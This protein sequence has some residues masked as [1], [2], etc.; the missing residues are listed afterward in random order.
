MNL[1]I[2]DRLI[3]NLTETDLLQKFRILVAFAESLTANSAKLPK[4]APTSLA[5]SPQRFSLQCQTATEKHCLCDVCTPSRHRYP[6]YPNESHPNKRHRLGTYYDKL[7]GLFI[8]SRQD[9]DG[10]VSPSVFLRKKNPVLGRLGK[11]A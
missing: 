1:E 7:L 3:S 2:S 6:D 5:V 10:W 11:T 9:R 8:S 4:H